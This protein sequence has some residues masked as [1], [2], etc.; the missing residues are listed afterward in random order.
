M[1][2]KL[3]EAAGHPKLRSPRLGLAV[4]DKHVKG[5]GCSLSSNGAFYEAFVC[6]NVLNGLSLSSTPLQVSI[7][8]CK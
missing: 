8:L 5:L 2:S 1:A 4:V 3:L 6:Q 7:Y